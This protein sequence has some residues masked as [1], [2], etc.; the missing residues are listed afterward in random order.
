[1]KKFLVFLT[2]AVLGI[3]CTDNNSLTDSQK[4]KLVSEV[5]PVTTS[6]IKVIEEVN[7]GPVIEALLNSPDFTF[8]VPG[9]NLNYDQA[10][11]AIK[12]YF[13]PIASQKSRI[14]SEKYT[15]IDESNV[16]YSAN[17]S[18]QVKFKDGHE[19]MQEPWVFQWLFR[20]SGDDWKVAVWSE[21][22]KEKIVPSAGAE[23]EQGELLKKFIGSWKCKFDSG[24]SADLDFKL[25]GTGIEG[26]YKIFSSGKLLTQ[27]KQIWGYE[28]D[29]GKI[30]G[31]QMFAGSD[32]QV[33]ALWFTGESQF[34]MYYLKDLENPGAASFKLTGEFK[35]P[36]E[37][38][39][40]I[41]DKD[42][43]MRV[44]TWKKVK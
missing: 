37:L 5:K 29:F 39:E 20:K 13:D 41:Y 26:D 27:G 21:A 17:S 12:S 31:V 11:G 28:K 7:A 18:W 38:V 30:I 15:V 33:A 2:L 1:M 35:S 4:E 23:L 43:V 19:L 40:T 36:G 24:E 42:K 8:V 14:I 44:D 16:L 6:L 25:L 32:I 9:A 3:S 10:A 22:G 34:T